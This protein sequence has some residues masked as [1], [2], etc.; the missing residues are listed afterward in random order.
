MTALICII[1]PDGSGKTTLVKKLVSTIEKEKLP[2]KYVWFRRPYFLSFFILGL[3]KFSGFTKYNGDRSGKITQ[4][5]FK[6]MPFKVLY[7]FTVLVDTL[8]YYL[9]RIGIP[10]KLGTTVVCDRWVQDIMID[11]SVDTNNLNFDDTLIGRAFNSIAAKATLVVAVDASQRTLIDRRP[12]TKLDTNL[13]TR[14]ALYHAYNQKYEISSLNSDNSVY[15][16]FRRLVDIA[17]MVGLKFVRPKKMYANVSNPAA[18]AIVGRRSFVI[19]ANWVFQ[20]TLIMSASERIFRFLFELVM[21]VTLFVLM[22][23]FVPL[24]ENLALSLIIAHTIDWSFNGNFWATQKFFGRKTDPNKL[25]GVLRKL[26]KTEHHQVAAIAVF[27]SLSR[28][29]F[30]PSSDLDMR[31]IRQKG[32]LGWIRT[33]LFVLKLRATSFIKKMPIDILILDNASQ[34]YE[35]ISCSESPVVIYD[36][37]N[38]FRQIND[39]CIS[40]E[41]IKLK[42]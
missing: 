20:G 13:R 36:P 11:I 21:T 39:T 5:N 8:F 37:K 40:P 34:T 27:G 25:I 3:S 15:T 33:N 6:S 1:G 4:F 23:Q 19:A 28:G 14:L 18:R 17:D 10:T 16:S 12:E 35:H 31:V 7:P 38:L 32:F 41:E 29:Q 42:D 2:V 22:S 9:L 30:S 24:V 26:T